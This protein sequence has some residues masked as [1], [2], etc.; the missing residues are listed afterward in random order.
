MANLPT[1]RRELQG[2]SVVFPSRYAQEAQGKRAPK[3]RT[4]REVWGHALPENFYL[5]SEMP[6]PMFFRGNFHKS[7]HEKR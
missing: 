7:K 1:Y 2:H 3:A 5:A 6:F 4:A